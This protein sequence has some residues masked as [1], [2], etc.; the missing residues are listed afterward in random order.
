MSGKIPANMQRF[1]ARRD[2]LEFVMLVPEGFME[3]PPEHRGVDLAGT[4]ATLLACLA[5]PSA[6][7]CLAVAAR[8]ARLI[9]SVEQWARSLCSLNGWTII[10]LVSGF[11]GEPGPGGHLHPCILVEATLTHEGAARTARIIALEDGR[12]WLIAH[13]L[14]STDLWPALGQTLE[15]SLLSIQLA[16][17]LGPTAPC[18]P[19]GPVPIVDMPGQSAGE[20]PRGRGAEV[21]DPAPQQAALAAAV[22]TARQLIAAGKHAQAEATVRQA[23]GDIQGS[24]SLARLYRERLIEL[25]SQRPPHTT[26]GTHHPTDNDPELKLVFGRALHWA[27]CAYPQPHTE[28]EGE[29]YA[30]GQAQDRAALLAILNGTTPPAT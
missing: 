24:V 11:T 22:S 4:G 20:W 9:G 19:G 6:D 3:A 17:P 30:R 27:L 7:A 8:P 16:R 1:P 23:D 29:D 12:R 21:F 14:C 5:P 26:R 2:D 10:G 28:V 15:R 18:V 25:M 13:A